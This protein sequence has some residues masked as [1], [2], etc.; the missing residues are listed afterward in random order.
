MGIGSRQVGDTIPLSLNLS[1]GAE[2]LYPQAIVRDALGQLV[3]TVNLDHVGEGLYADNSL[4]MPDTPYITALYT[5]YTDA[6][7]TTQSTDYTEISDVFV[8]KQTITALAVSEYFTATFEESDDND[9]SVTIEDTQEIEVE[10]DEQ[11]DAVSAIIDTDEI[12]F[13]FEESDD[14]DVSFEL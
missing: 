4:T 2:N 10:V 6:G 9:I 13:I 11:N 5:V 3:S 14:I 8:L 7:R 12:K 1:D